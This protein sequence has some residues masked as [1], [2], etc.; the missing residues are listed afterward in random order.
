MSECL[1]TTRFIFKGIRGRRERAA[2][3][4]RR[5]LCGILF[6]CFEGLGE[7]GNRGGGGGGGGGRALKAMTP[8]REEEVATSSHTSKTWFAEA[9]LPDVFW[10]TRLSQTKTSL[11]YSAH[12]SRLPFCSVSRNH[13]H[14]SP[15]LPSACESSVYFA[16]TG[17]DLLWIFFW[18]P[19]SW[20]ALFTAPISRLFLAIISVLGELVP[21]QRLGLCQGDKN[22]AAA[23]GGQW[24]SPPALALLL[25]CKLP[26]WPHGLP[27]KYTHHPSQTMTNR[28]DNCQ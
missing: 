22:T 18:S 7:L 5:C 9:L 26:T 3:K 20:T 4:R 17:R 21:G 24:H 2:W 23:E 14:I 6:V 11:D 25:V 27:P 15:R 13:S 16:Q 8:G 19:W 10:I 28:G 1:V 12:C